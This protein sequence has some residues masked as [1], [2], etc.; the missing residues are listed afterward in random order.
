MLKPNLHL[1][2]S[3]RFKNED[4]KERSD[5]S[6]PS[7]SP[8]L[9][10]ST[11]N[12]IEVQTLTS[13]NSLTS[14]STLTSTNT[15]IINMTN[16]VLSENSELNNTTSSDDPAATHTV[17]M[18]EKTSSSLPNC[19]YKFNKVTKIT[20]IAQSPI[21]TSVKQIIHSSHQISAH[22]VGRFT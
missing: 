5:S 19:Y 20:S 3:L 17:K 4:N 21:F 22:C 1:L 10:L 2:G 14:T 6:S 18:T 8:K 7:F 13:T 11:E 12:P 9:T 15:S 16:S